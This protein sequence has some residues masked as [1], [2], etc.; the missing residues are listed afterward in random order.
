MVTQEGE[1]IRLE[2]LKTILI[3]NKTPVNG[4][5]NIPAGGNI[6][7]LEI[8]LDKD[9]LIKLGQL[10]ILENLTQGNQIIH[11]NEQIIAAY[12]N[13]S[14][15]KIIEIQKTILS[16]E[17][18]H[19]ISDL[20]IEKLALEIIDISFKQI[21][22]DKCNKENTIFQ[23]LI[24]AIQDKPQRAWTV[25]IMAETI[26]TNEKAIQRIFNA[27][28]KTTPNKFLQKV[29]VLKAAELIENN[30]LTVTEACLSVGFTNQS[31]MAKLFKKIIGASPST[32]KK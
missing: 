2:P 30:N 25:K 10:E 6:R 28:L 13:L 31:H 27:E 11:Y 32:F 14:S 15:I 23:R 9:F 7:G 21:D 8:R 16:I 3:Y 5:N 12:I 20:E 29:R 4:S 1:N 22:K 18:N 24:Q 26:N 19:K 17:N